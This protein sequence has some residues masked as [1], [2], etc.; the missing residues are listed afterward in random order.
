VPSGSQ[1]SYQVHEGHQVLNPKRATAGRQHNEWVRV[2]SVRPTPQ[3][4][5]LHAILVKERHA[6]LTPGLANGHEHKLATHPR[7]ERMRHT[8][9]P[10]LN[11][12]IRRS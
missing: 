11:L 1:L 8:N 5:A 4:R 7:M 10:L 12:P 9:S 3:K 6:I 2:P